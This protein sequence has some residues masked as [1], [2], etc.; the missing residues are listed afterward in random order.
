MTLFHALAGEW[1]E[2][3]DAD[4]AEIAVRPAFDVLVSEVMPLGR[5]AAYRL[6]SGELAAVQVALRARWEA[7]LSP[8][9]RQPYRPHVTVQDKVTPEE[10]RRTVTALRA[11]FVP[12]PVRAVGLGLWS[13]EGGPWAPLSRHAFGWAAPGP[14]EPGRV[15]S[16]GRDPG[17]ATS[18]AVRGNSG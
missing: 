17:S 14:A 11:G 7:G 2:A 12:Y 16:G 9:D 1:R 10:A 15:R 6:E 5:G 13:C 8:R 18:G 3:V 4:L